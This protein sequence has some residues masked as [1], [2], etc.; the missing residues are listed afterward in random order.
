MWMPPPRSEE[1]AE[2]WRL[3]D[4]VDKE[5]LSSLHSSA[6]SRS[7]V[8]S[9][10]RLTPRTTGLWFCYFLPKNCWIIRYPFNPAITNAIAQPI[11][12]VTAPLTNGPIFVLSDVN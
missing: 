6:L 7:A 10:T 1:R 5:S 8:A 12:L 9:K 3:Y 11:A 2:A 4:R